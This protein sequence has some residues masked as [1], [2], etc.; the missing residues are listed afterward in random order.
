[1]LTHTISFASQPTMKMN[2]RNQCLNF[3]LIDRRS[4]NCDADWDKHPVEG[5]YTC[6]MISVDLKS[7]SATFEGA[8]TYQ[9]QR[10]NIEFD[11]Q[12]EEPT[13]IRLFVAWKSEGYKELRVFAHLIEHGKWYGWSEAALEEYYRKYISQ[14]SVYTDPIRDTWS[15]H[16]G[17][18]L[19]TRL[20]LDLTQSSGILNVT[21]SEGSWNG[22][23]KRSI[24]IGPEM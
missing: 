6:S 5:V 22:H 9:L 16:D 19:M 18:M 1:M 8:L 12:P 21:I 24:W 20:E 23:T 14:T 15:T 2:I 11:D 13:C 7:S 10:K 4:F 17:T 3:K